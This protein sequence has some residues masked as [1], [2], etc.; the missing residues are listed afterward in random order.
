MRMDRV[1]KH[2]LT[3][4]SVEAGGQQHLVTSQTMSNRGE[5][6]R[7]HHQRQRG[8]GKN[9][10]DPA[11]KSQKSIFL[12]KSIWQLCRGQFITYGEARSPFVCDASW[13][14]IESEAGQPLASIFVAF[15]Y[16]LWRENPRGPGVYKRLTSSTNCSCSEKHQESFQR[17]L[18]HLNFLNNCWL[19]K[20]FI[21]LSSSLRKLPSYSVCML[22]ET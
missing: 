9:G 8:N 20:L 21:I 4:H 22:P 14:I 10:A 12:K 7:N 17:S 18:F 3:S 6:S 1:A 13:D 11:K 5:Q 16:F 15:V 19:G 2:W